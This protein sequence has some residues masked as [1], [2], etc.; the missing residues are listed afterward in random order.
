MGYCIQNMVLDGTSYP[1]AQL[2]DPSTLI[3]YDGAESQRIAQ[4]N[5]FVKPDAIDSLGTDAYHLYPTSGE[6]FKQIEN[7]PDVYYRF[8]SYKSNFYGIRLCYSDKSEIHILSGATTSE[9]N[10]N[11]ALCYFGVYMDAGFAYIYKVIQNVNK[12]Y[13]D[14]CGGNNNYGRLLYSLFGGIIVTS[15]GGGATH[16]AKR[17][18]QLKDLSSYT[19]DILMVS[20]GGG[21]GLLVGETAY[22]GKDA[23]GIT[24]NGSNSADQSTG[25]AFGQGESST[26]KSGGGGGLYGGYKGGS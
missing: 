25:Y 7:Y 3:A 17:T 12:T 4:Y 26:N 9:V 6:T 22:E 5:G 18:G 10:N 11:Q 8:Y 16:I 13:Y 23:G 19:S 15:N 24:G 2:N 14:S 1:L 20:G 21:G